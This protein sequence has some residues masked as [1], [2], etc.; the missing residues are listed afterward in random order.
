MVLGGLRINSENLEVSQ[1]ALQEHRV[2]TVKLGLT[3]LQ[4]A[5]LKHTKRSTSGQNRLAMNDLLF[6]VFSLGM[7]SSRLCNIISPGWC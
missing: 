5:D 3:H 1:Q 6:P 2:L 4:A 7:L